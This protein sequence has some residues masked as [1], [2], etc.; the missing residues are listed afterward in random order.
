M[1]SATALAIQMDLAGCSCTNKDACRHAP[2]TNNSESVDDQNTTQSSKP[3]GACARSAPKIA[4]PNRTHWAPTTAICQ[5]DVRAHAPC[6]EGFSAWSLFRIYPRSHQFFVILSNANNIF[7]GLQTINNW[8]N[9]GSVLCQ[10]GYFYIF[11]TVK[12][13][14]YV[15]EERASLLILLVT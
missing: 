13:H 3:L 7:S 10:S 11:F 12:L 14:S 15:S 1:P 8:P 2:V 9:S 6:W 5:V 4:R